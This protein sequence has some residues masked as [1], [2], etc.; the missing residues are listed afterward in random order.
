[1]VSPFMNPIGEIHRAS[2]EILFFSFICLQLKLILYILQFFGGNDAR[3]LIYSKSDDWFRFCRGKRF[4]PPTCYDKILQIVL[5]RTVRINQ[6]SNRMEFCILKNFYYAT[7]LGMI[8]VIMGR[9]IHYDLDSYLNLPH[10]FSHRY[11]SAL[12]YFVLS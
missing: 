3:S 5:T 12:H 9:K 11:S 4:F 2:V 6:C 1:M 10:E 8:I 7:G